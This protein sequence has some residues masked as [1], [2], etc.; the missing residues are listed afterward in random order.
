VE[1][2]TSYYSTGLTWQNKIGC[3]G[4]NGETK[5]FPY[6]K[7]GPSY[8]IDE[9]ELQ[10]IDKIVKKN[11]PENPKYVRKINAPQ[12]AEFIFLLKGIGKQKHKNNSKC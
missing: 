12:Y 6:T 11:R 9:K 3:G 7:A 2:Y 10:G 4:D 8:T 5:A 1:I